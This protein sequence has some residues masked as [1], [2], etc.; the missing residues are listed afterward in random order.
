MSD[1]EKE[2]LSG[3]EKGEERLENEIEKERDGNRGM[4]RKGWKLR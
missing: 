1:L 2:N 3:E 4:L